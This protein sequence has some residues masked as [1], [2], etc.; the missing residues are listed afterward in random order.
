MIIITTLSIRVVS[1]LAVL[2]PTSSFWSNLVLFFSHIVSL[3]SLVISILHMRAFF[4]YKWSE[5]TSSTS[6]SSTTSHAT[7]SD[8]APLVISL[9]LIIRIVILLGCLSHLILLHLLLILV[10]CLIL[11]FTSSM[12]I[13]TPMMIAAPVIITS[14]VMFTTSVPSIMITSSSLIIIFA[15]L[16]YLIICHLSIC[17]IDYSSQILARFFN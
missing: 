1:S 15:S 8:S 4:H 17:S 3:R 14:P 11:F 16:T 13:A 10:S 7:S 6:H 5:Y 12:M 2:S 9:F